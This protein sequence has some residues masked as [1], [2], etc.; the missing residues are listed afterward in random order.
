MHPTIL[1]TDTQ[2]I[3][4]QT[5][6]KAQKVSTDTKSNLIVPKLMRSLCIKFLVFGMHVS[7]GK[8]KEATVTGSVRQ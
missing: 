5:D 4:E 2:G 6:Q 8:K 7:H 1:A 3:R